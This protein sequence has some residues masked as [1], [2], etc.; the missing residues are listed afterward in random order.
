M[1]PAP[2]PGRDSETRDV[3]I[4]LVG[5]SRPETAALLGQPTGE[6][7]RSPAKVW[8]YLTGDCA[9]DVYFYLDVTRNDFFALHYETRASVASAGAGSLNGAAANG[10]L[11]RLHDAR[12]TR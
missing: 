5:L 3:E 12:H 4:K 11:R 7:E 9:V 10:C 1:P 6:S 2:A 8:Q